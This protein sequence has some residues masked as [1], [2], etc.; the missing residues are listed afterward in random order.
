[1]LH[2]LCSPHFKKLVMH[3]IQLLSY[4]CMWEVA[5]HDWLI[6]LRV[7]QGVDMSNCIFLSG[8]YLLCLFTT[9]GDTQ[10]SFIWEGSAPRSNP[11]PIY[12]PFLTEKVPPS[13]TLYW[14]II[15][16]PFH[17]LSLELPILFNC[18]KFTVFKISI[19]YKTRKFSQ[20]FHT[21][22]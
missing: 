9:W 2:K 14:Q 13:Y 1:M 6:C 12:I 7:T 22:S 20:L 15:L 4:G 8:H 17:I 18:R 19:Y 11:L 10:Q 3:G 21:H 16:Y 5:D